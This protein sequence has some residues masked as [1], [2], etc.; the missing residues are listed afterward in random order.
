MPPTEILPVVEWFEVDFLSLVEVDLK[1][2]L[3]CAQK[4]M[5][6]DP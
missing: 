1:F 3:P 5:D 4:W 2:S 6:Q